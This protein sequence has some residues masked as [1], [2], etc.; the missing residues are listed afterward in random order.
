MIINRLKIKKLEDEIESLKFEIGILKGENKMLKN[1]AEY[2]KQES[3]KQYKLKE[4]CREYM[5][6]IKNKY[7][8][9]KDIYKIDEE[10]IQ[11]ELALKETG[12]N[13]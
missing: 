4:H 11:K 7:D 8:I 6:Y 5:N 3:L 9:A 2:E 1:I 12:N 10:I 13:E